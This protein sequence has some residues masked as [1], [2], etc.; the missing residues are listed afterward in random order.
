MTTL[1][2]SGGTTRTVTGS[3]PLSHP[4][5][6]RPEVLVA[7]EDELAV[8]H[9]LRIAWSEMA[10]ARVDLPRRSHRALIEREGSQGS[11]WDC[12]KQV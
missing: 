2:L 4:A 3:E 1:G 5:I 9:F 6:F 11:A 12:A 10:R 7:F 8:D